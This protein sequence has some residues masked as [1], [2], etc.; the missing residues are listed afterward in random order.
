MS[1]DERQSPRTAI[2]T[3]LHDTDSKSN[4]KPTDATRERQNNM[5]GSKHHSGRRHKTKY[6]SKI[7][8]RQFVHPVPKHQRHSKSGIQHEGA[9][10]ED[11]LVQP[12][13]VQ[14]Q[15]RS[16]ENTTANSNSLGLAERLG[17]QAPFRTFRVHSDD[18]IPD[19][20]TRS[21]KRRRS[22]SSTTSYLEPAAANDLSD[23]DY[24]PSHHATIPR[25]ANRRPAPGNGRK[26]SSPTSSQGS[27]MILP[28]PEKLLKSYE[29]RPR[30]KTRL[31]RY[32]IKG[33]N[34]HSEKTRQ[35]AKKDREEK[36]HKKHKRKE[37]SGAALMHDFA[38]KNVTNDRLT[39]SCT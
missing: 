38:A 6:P 7:R 22:R 2:R 23:N 15:Q 10:D 25:S 3:W 20:Q 1:D 31:D 19:I 4:A 16:G 8:D 24:D 13:H 37:K 39:V 5:R 18:D 32:E 12:V 29:R 26:H 17:L 34:G 27:G 9:T 14:S 11:F 21:R 33:D 30:R 28:S 36:K 35:S